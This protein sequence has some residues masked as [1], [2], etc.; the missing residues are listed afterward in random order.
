MIVMTKTKYV[1]PPTRTERFLELY[2]KTGN[3]TQA[4]FEVFDCSSRRSAQALGSK[5]LKKAKPMIRSLMDDKGLSF[6]KFLDIAIEK[7]E[8][9]GKVEWFDRLMAIS[10]YS[11]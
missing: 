1:L 9:T 6:G 3:A 8:T 11:A 10:G 2:L 5:Y 4:A 7:M